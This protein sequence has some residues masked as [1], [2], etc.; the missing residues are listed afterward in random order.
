MTKT[1]SSAIA[2]PARQRRLESA[3]QSPMPAM[4]SG[5][6]SFVSAASHGEDREGNE[7]VLVEVPEREEQE[8]ARERDGVELVQRQPLDGG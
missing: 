3:Y 5:I 6:S 8:R 2:P 4:T 1:P 7:P